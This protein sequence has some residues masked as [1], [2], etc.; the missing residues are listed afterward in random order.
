MGIHN[1]GPR[2]AE[3]PAP[4]TVPELSP[5]AGNPHQ[6]VVSCRD[7]GST[8]RG[9]PD[10]ARGIKVCWAILDGPPADIE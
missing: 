1:P 4:K 7:K 10:D 2:R 5:R 9:K 3:I 6:I 8:R